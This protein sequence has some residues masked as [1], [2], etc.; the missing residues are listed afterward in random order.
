MENGKKVNKRRRLLLDAL[1]TFESAARNDSFADAAAE[2]SVTASAVSHQIR[3]LEEH[4]DVTLFDRSGKHP[5]LTQAGQQLARNLEPLFGQMHGA[6]DELKGSAQVHLS[7]SAMSALG[8]SWLARRAMAF[9]TQ[10]RDLQLRISTSDELVDLYAENIDVGI[11]FG[12][13]VYPGLVSELLTTTEAFP[14]CSPS[15]LEANRS[16]LRS[17]QGLADSVLINDESSSRNAALPTWRSWLQAAGVSRSD[18]RFAMTFQDPRLAQEA[19]VFGHGFCMGISCLVSDD[20][21]GGRLVAPFDL[22][23]ASPFSFWIVSSP[24]RIES[25]KVV[26]FKEWLKRQVHPA[27]S[28]HGG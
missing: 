19:A 5:I 16:R 20:I 22:K 7:V 9:A 25:P 3:R 14:V 18:L 8:A 21:A 23:L 26:R 17:P 15:F 10:N 4:L 13:G 24:S 2:M 11:R 1:H 12:A 6:V 27:P 28:P